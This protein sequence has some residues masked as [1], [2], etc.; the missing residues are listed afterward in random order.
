MRMRRVVTTG[1]SSGPSPCRPT[2]HDVSGSLSRPLSGQPTRGLHLELLRSDIHEEPRV[3]TGARRSRDFPDVHSASPTWRSAMKEY[4]VAPTHTSGVVMR[5]VGPRDAT[6]VP[7]SISTWSW[8]D[9]PR[10]RGSRYVNRVTRLGRRS[11]ARWFRAAT[12]LCPI[13]KDVRYFAFK[14][15]GNCLLLSWSIPDRSCC[16]LFVHKWAGQFAKTRYF[17]IPPISRHTV[18]VSAS[19]VPGAT[20]AMIS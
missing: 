11:P 18:S 15:S 19:S 8:S 20:A 6:R 17:T 7:L 5:H 12:T 10:A 13:G 3:K 1:G 14:W 9:L 16:P 2:P 4:A